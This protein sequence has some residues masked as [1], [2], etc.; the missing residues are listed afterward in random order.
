MERLIYYFKSFKAI[1][2][3][4]TILLGQCKAPS[5]SDVKHVMSRCVFLI[6]VQFLANKCSALITSIHITYQ[7]KSNLKE[8]CN[9]LSEVSDNTI[10]LRELWF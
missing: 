5:S 3:G 1:H 7:V 4:A 6:S 2:T 8:I 10:H 9:V